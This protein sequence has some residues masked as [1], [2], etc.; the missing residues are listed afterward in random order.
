MQQPIVLYD[1]D[2][3]FCLMLAGLVARRTRVFRME[4]WQKFVRTAEAKSLISP[5]ELLFLADKIRLIDTNSQLI[6]GVDAWA[7]LLEHYEDL[8]PLNW[9]AERLGLKEA[10]SRGMDR[11]GR[12]IRKLCFT[13][14]GRR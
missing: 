11:G 3:S 10:L 14:G 9:L 4:S 7:Y 13:C 5:A 2:C 1:E 6:E 12:T 8:E